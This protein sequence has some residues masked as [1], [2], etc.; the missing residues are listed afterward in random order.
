MSKF[1]SLG[2]TEYSNTLAKMKDF[3]QNR[4][5]ES[6]D[7]IWFTE[8]PSVYTQGLNGKPEHLINPNN[9]PVVQTDRGGQIT[10]HGPGQLI[11]YFMINLVQNKLGV[12]QCVNKL[13]NIIIKQLQNHNVDAYADPDAPGVYVQRAK[14]AALGL[15]IRKG[16]SYHG[17]SLNNDMDLSPY[18]SINPCGYKDLKVTQLKD[19][20]IHLT[21]T[22]LINELTPIIK[23]EIY[24]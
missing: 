8:H 11:V 12:K 7:E 23:Q 17:L 22:E 14:V 13:E 15:K 3:T 5:S 9:I 2:L 21:Q 20:N 19:V 4:N 6:E 24:G 10:Y 16:C 18:N 1:I